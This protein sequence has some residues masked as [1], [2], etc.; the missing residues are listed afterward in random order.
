MDNKTLRQES[1]NVS[2]ATPG[3]RRVKLRI[4]LLLEFWKE[5]QEIRFQI[6]DLD[7]LIHSRR[8]CSYFLAASGGG[9]TLLSVM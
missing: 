4:F 7:L 9:L 3:E 1:N 8:H 6:E 2:S 5:T